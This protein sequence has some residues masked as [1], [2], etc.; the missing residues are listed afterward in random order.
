MNTLT[1][2][3]LNTIASWRKTYGDAHNVMIPAHEAEELVSRLL[4]A[5]KHL[6]EIGINQN[7]GWQEAHCAKLRAES[8]EAQL[9]ELRGQKGIVAWQ[10]KGEPWKIILDRDIEEVRKTSGSWLPLSVVTVPP[11]ASQQVAWRW[12]DGRG[13]N[14]TTDKRRAD[15]LVKDGVPVEALALIQPNREQLRHLVDVVWNAVTES[16]EVPS[17]EWADELIDKAFSDLPASQPYTVPD[18]KWVNPD[19]HYADEN[20]FAEGWNA[21]RAT[22]LQSGNSELVDFRDRCRKLVGVGART[23]DFAVFANI[24]SALRRSNCLSAIERYM[25]V[26]V[27]TDDNDDTPMYREL[28]NWGEEPAKYIETFKAALPKFSTAD[29]PVVPDGWVTVPVEPTEAMLLV[30]GMT[31]SFDSM[32]AKY[33]KMLA[34]APRKEE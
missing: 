4:A 6:A 29:Y 10:S 20:R 23:P 11:A 25:S 31:G 21:C 14:S 24:E 2:E 7:R 15:E 16:E 33:Q 19:I 30:L 28:L 1:N 12:F 17:T 32:I 22:M 5:E 34:A 3:R 9:A 27:G 26:H 18:E 13:Y 8:A